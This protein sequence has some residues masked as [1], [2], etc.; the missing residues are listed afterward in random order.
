MTLAPETTATPKAAAPSA[1]VRS[2]VVVPLRFPDGFEAVAEVLS[3]SGLTDGK[4]HLL[5]ALGEWEAALQGA[6][7]GGAGP[8]VRL[9]PAAAGGRGADC[10]R[11]RLPALPPPGR[12][13]H[14]PVFEA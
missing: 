1:A 10:R 11:G 8:L 3:F 4:E 5:L 14:R 13:W 7:Q 2:R 12:P 6:T 9:W